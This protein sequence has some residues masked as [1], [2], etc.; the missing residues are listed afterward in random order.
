MHSCCQCEGTPV[1]GGGGVS[2][3]RAVA[4]GILGAMSN[5]NGGPI[6]EPDWSPAAFSL[7]LPMAL[8]L[9]GSLVVSLVVWCIDGIRSIGITDPLVPWVAQLAVSPFIMFAAV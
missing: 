7:W 9:T 8:V 4:S 6:A 2:Q 3:R 5:P 1:I